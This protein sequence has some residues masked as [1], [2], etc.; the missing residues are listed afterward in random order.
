MI[1]G[2]IASNYKLISFCDIYARQEKRAAS[3]ARIAHP[4][5]KIT[6][7]KRLVTAGGQQRFAPLAACFPPLTWR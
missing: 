2:N 4:E 7:L 3:R 6:Q 5:C 1:S